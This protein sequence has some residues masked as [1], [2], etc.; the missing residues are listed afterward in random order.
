MK[1][2]SA[3][4][5]A[6]TML[7]GCNAMHREI[8]IPR[9]RLQEMVD[10]K[11]PYDKNAV[12]ARFKLDSPEVY[13]AGSNIGMKLNYYASLFDKELQGNADFNGRLAYKPE[14]G[15]FYLTDFD[16][17]DITINQANFS[18]EDQLKTAILK[19]VNNYL[20]GYPVYRL[21]EA[22]F[23]QKLGK[24]LLKEV[25]VEGESLIVVMDVGS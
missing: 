8:T 10:K 5:V 2:L 9:A 14:E 23:K 12:V 4:A 13:F 24:L 25:R 1:C 3:V 22:G 18:H 6:L 16:I 15:A 11:F 20:D 19:V 7:A 17:V 21:D